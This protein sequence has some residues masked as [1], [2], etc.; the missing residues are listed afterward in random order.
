MTEMHWA[1]FALRDIQ[2]ALDKENYDAAA[3][4][5]NEAIEAI[6][7]SDT[8]SSGGSP[9]QDERSKMFIRRV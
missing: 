3:C 8:P 6:I 7:A 1:V 5:I 2:N 4:H 9:Q